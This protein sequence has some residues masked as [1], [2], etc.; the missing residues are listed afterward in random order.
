MF[1]R[2]ASEHLRESLVSGVA[3]PL[4]DAVQDS[5]GA[6][7]LHMLC[8]LPTKVLSALGR[9]RSLVGYLDAAV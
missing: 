9:S 4:R 7:C 3:V 5:L 1:L 8:K 6:S 2:V